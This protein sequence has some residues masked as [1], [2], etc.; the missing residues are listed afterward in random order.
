MRA[1]PASIV[2]PSDSVNLIA[3]P[4]L[5][6]TR[7]QALVVPPGASVAAMV[8]L[9]LPGLAAEARR[10]VRVTIGDCEIL[11]GLWE[12]VRPKAGTS[13]V[14][15]VL[16]SGGNSRTI[17]ALVVTVAALA[18][19][20]FYVAPALVGALGVTGFAATAVSAAAVA[21]TVLASTMLFN[22]LVPIKQSGTAPASEKVS[23]SYSIQGI[24]NALNPGGA[25]PNLMG[26]HRFAPPYAAFPY[27]EQT[28]PGG[29]EDFYPN[30]LFVALFNFGY[31]P[32]AISN[33][34]LGETAIDQFPDVEI[35]IREGYPDD[36]PI[37]IAPTQVIED[38]FGGE[39]SFDTGYPDVDTSA[40]RT[41][42]RDIT[43][44]EVDLFWP[45]GLVKFNP[46]GS[47]HLA[48]VT[49][50][51][52][53]RLVGD[54]SWTLAA[55]PAVTNESRQPLRRQ[56]RWELPAR[57]Q[58]EVKVTRLSPSDLDT[59]NTVDRVVWSALRGYRPESPISFERPLA[60]VAVR[61]KAGGQLNGMINNLNADVARVCLD[62]DSGTQ[63]WVQR[64]TRNPAA[65]YRYALQC[66]ANAFPKGDAEI[67]IAALEEWHEY[68]TD[69]GLTYDRVHDYAASL[70]EVLTDVARA[71][72]ATP[73]DNGVT[74]SVVVDRPQTLIVGHIS[75]RNSWGFA[76]ERAYVRFPEGFRVTF[77]DETNG[78]QTSERIVPWPGFEGEPEITEEVQLPGITNPDLIYKEARRRMYELIY[79]PD[80]YTANQDIEGLVLAR[81]DLSVLSHDVID[82]T[83][84]AGR[85]KSTGATDG[86]DFVVLDTLVT[87]ETAVSY[88]V[89]FRLADGTSVLRTVINTAF[90]ETAKLW[91]SPDDSDTT[92]PEAGDLAFFGILG[93]ECR[94]VI[95]QGIEVGDNLTA[96]F[97]L[98]DHAPEIDTLVDADEVPEWNRLAA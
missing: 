97:T 92:L 76:G 20:Q 89:R 30:Q 65:L 77:P 4:H 66:N 73:R 33:V 14:V 70:W 69:K 68:C 11:P 1:S 88:A 55:T 12:R 13:V 46:D 78:Y 40:V 90:G 25:I 39:I 83:Q 62:W 43:E 67:D 91:L 64:A 56:Y 15:R 34:R 84:V 51:I 50:T 23:P 21:G 54:V 32:V 29:P 44:A 6:V 28:S 5:D 2:T 24:Q 3:L 36:A 41:T 9:A 47:R 48:G 72:R 96:R 81:G 79:R 38:Q 60:L 59:S 95:V 19:G 27:T 86:A 80:R 22:A 26:Q 16:P 18:V 87:I 53:Y 58:Y 42:A 7:R 35:E 37:T 71:G 74:W 8:A 17:L 85:V 45:A 61:I 82:R 75:P 93:S 31:G 63:L 57:G 52:E 98:L 10:H 94:E 49:L